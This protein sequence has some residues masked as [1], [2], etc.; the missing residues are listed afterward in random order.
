MI[1]AAEARRGSERPR[2]PALHRSPTG[3]SKAG[4]A[5]RYLQEDPVAESDKTRRP[6]WLW[7]WV[8]VFVVAVLLLL[9]WAWPARQPPGSGDVLRD[10]AVVALSVSSPAAAARAD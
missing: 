4:R 5:G 10:G 9:L 2:E 8:V 7:F 1:P 6:G 3:N